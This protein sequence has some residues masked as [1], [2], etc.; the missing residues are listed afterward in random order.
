MPAN[1]RNATLFNPNALNLACFAT[2]ERLI[3]APV[4]SVRENVLDWGHLPWLHKT[5]L[6][7]IELDEAG[8]WG[9][10]A[11]SNRSLHFDYVL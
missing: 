7:F 9:W 10:V 2:Y 5:S 1:Q 4:K 3:G 6:N 11:W 8:E